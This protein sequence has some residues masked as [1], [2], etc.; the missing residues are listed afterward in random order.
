VVGDGFRMTCER[1]FTRRVHY[2]I[3]RDKLVIATTMIGEGSETISHVISLPSGS[4]A[5]VY[6]TG[7]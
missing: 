1:L 7:R 6:A 2:S 4:I 5:I 3:A